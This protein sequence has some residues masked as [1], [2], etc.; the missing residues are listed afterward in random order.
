MALFRLAVKD[1]NDIFGIIDLTP[2]DGQSERPPAHSPNFSYSREAKLKR[3]SIHEKVEFHAEDSRETNIHKQGINDPPFY[4]LIL[5]VLDAFLIIG[6]YI[7][8]LAIRYPQA[9]QKFLFWDVMGIFLLATIIPLSLI[10]GHSK[11]TDMQSLRFMSEHVIVSAFSF[12]LASFCIYAISA[13]NVEMAPARFNVSFTLLLFP[14]L[15]LGYR[16]QISSRINQQQRFK[17]LFILGSGPVAQDFYRLLRHHKWPHDL[18][19]FSIKPTEASSNL[20]SQDL[21]SPIVE[22]DLFTK[23]TSSQS[24]IV[25]VVLAEDTSYIPKELMQKLVT[26]HFSKIP[27]QTL[28]TFFAREWKMVPTG[29]VSLSWAFE[30]GFRLNSPSYER[31]KRLSD[32]ILSAMIL[33]IFSPVLIIL[34]LLIRMGSSGPAIFR[35][36]RVGRHGRPFTLAKFRTM[37]TGSDKAQKTTH[38]EDKRIIPFGNFLRKSRLDELP[39][40]WNVLK[41]EMSLIGPRAE[42]IKCVDE[43]ENKIPFYHFRHVVKPG[44]TGWAQVNYPYGQDETDAEEKLKYDLYYIRHFSF[45]LDL[46]I[47]LKTLYVMLFARGR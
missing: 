10:G 12:L 4:R 8:S 9:F 44:I 42:W 38:E 37:R 20:I 22:D 23:L 43:Y 1:E 41:G 3:S 33:I 45:G 30:K 26:L 11:N 15:S 7:G 21:E 16:R 2:P 14:V 34:P 47:C 27:V 6:I 24:D 28:D 19:F 39:Q 29:H 18:R 36:T 31:F 32:I 13:F 5:L 35:Q 25:S 46:S 17:S 40:L